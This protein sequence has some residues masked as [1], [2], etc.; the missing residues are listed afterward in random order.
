MLQDPA[1]AIAALGLLTQ[2]AGA[3]L[4]AVLFVALRGYA[5]RRSYFRA[6]GIA[7]IAL[8]LALLAVLTV[9]GRPDGFVATV[10]YAT[11]R[12]AYQV[13]KLVFIGFLAAGVASYLS[14]Q[15]V[16]RYL[17]RALP[18]AVG[19]GVLTGLV[20]PTINQAVALQGPVALAVFGA[21]AW[22]LLR[23]PRPRASLGS[24]AMGMVF[25]AM[26]MLWAG[27]T[28]AFPLYDRPAPFLVH[29]LMIGIVRHN[30][31]IDLLLQM[32]LGYGMVLLLME[33][34]RREIHLAHAHLERAH[35]QLKRTAEHDPLTG[36]LNRLAFAEGEGLPAPGTPGVALLADLD[37]LKVVN[38]SLGHAAGDDLLDRA[39][40]ALRSAVRPNGT[41]YR[42][43]GDEFLMLVPGAH[44]T[45]LCAKVKAEAARMATP[46]DAPLLFSVG[47]A[48]FGDG[49]SLDDAIREA[50]AAMYRDKAVRRE[51]RVSTP[52]PGLRTG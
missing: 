38:D 7:W 15:P 36:A 47:A 52:L 14:G 12:T 49:L 51:G 31:Y 6:W 34:G 24:A 26:A 35:A 46:H 41:L 33:D 8:S 9:Y 25:I 30:S 21:C 3:L 22:S 11:V 48:E 16:D 39:A 43:G 40:A 37:N 19:Y 50:D 10:G 13:A 4:L 42:W 2:L 45:E 5:D 28:V 1:G 20:S 17:R 29:A 23:L 27:Y 18:L 32:L 44:A